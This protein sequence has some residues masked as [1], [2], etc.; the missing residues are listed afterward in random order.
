MLANHWLVSEQFR[1][2]SLILS[3]LGLASFLIGV[4]EFA[5]RLISPEAFELNYRFPGPFIST[6][7]ACLAMA[8]LGLAALLLGAL[9]WK[10]HDTIAKRISGSDGKEQAGKS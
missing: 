8:T 7:Q 10:V 6:P 9:A 4:A 3:L 2:A 5:S 1:H